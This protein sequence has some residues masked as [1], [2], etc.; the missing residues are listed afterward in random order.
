[1]SSIKDIVKKLRKY[2][3]R[4][5]KA[6]TA[7]MQGD[8]HSVFKGSGLE[9]DDIREY[10]YGDDVRSLNWKVTAKGHGAYI[11]TYKEEKEQNVFFILDVS[12]S[13][14]IGADGQQ[15]IDIS[16]EICGVLTLSAL[17]EASSVGLLCY[18]DQKERYV[19]PSKG[20]KHAYRIIK[21]IFSLEPTSLKTDINKAIR[22]AMQIIK[23]KSIIVLISDFIDSDYE[24][25]LKGLA[26]R[27]DLVVIHISDQRESVFP[28]LGIVPVFDKE[29]QKKIWINTAS[30]EFRQKVQ[31]KFAE[32]QQKLEHLCKRYN[33][34]Y[35]SLNTSE[36]YVPSLIKMFKF[37]QI[38]KR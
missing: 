27:H 4:I 14:E 24:A 21:N 10:S 38:N 1:M 11:N 18:T 7:Q 26:K 16:K 23:R 9:F 19:K 2:E 12:A 5:R 15:K 36:D 37:R 22:L 29:T 31:G 13:Q 17:R 34:N 3:I 28:K 20:V 35:L 25:S 6:V 32:E 30:A 8:Y 33:A